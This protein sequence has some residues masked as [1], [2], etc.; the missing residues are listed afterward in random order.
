MTFLL[1]GGKLTYIRFLNPKNGNVTSTTPAQ[2]LF[3][4]L[5]EKRWFDFS[6]IAWQKFSFNTKFF[7]VTNSLD[8]QELRLLN[9]FELS[10]KSL[11]MLKKSTTKFGFSFRICLKHMIVLIFICFNMLW[12]D[13]IYPRNFLR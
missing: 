9:R 11:K 1:R 10:M 13:Y 2:L 3:W 6:T 5:L 12:T 4:K 8:C 7:V